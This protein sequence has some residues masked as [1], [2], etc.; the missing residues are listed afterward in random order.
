MEYMPS[1]VLAPFRSLQLLHCCSPC[2]V[3]F[4]TVFVIA[5]LLFVHAALFFQRKTMRAG[6][7]SFADDPLVV[8]ANA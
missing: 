4:A 1:L 8:P 2:Y 3:S 5:D 6:S 7:R